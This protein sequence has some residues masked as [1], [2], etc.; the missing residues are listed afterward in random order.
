[1]AILSHYP[2]KE[3]F[4]L[5]TSLQYAE[6]N[7]LNAIIRVG[8]LNISFTNLHLPWDSA[9]RQEK[10]IAM[11]DEYIHSQR[12]KADFFILLG[13][14]NGNIN[15][16]INRFLLGNQSIEGKESNPYWNDLQSCSYGCR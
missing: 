14:F 13:D 10:Q 1:M 15:S 8:E 16:S 12:E 5:H 7:A 3:T 6:S 9:L 2:L 11:I 4:F